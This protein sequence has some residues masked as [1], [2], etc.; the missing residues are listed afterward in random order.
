V[1]EIVRATAAH[2][3]E[4]AGTMRV[5]DVIGV[6]AGLDGGPREALAR[7]MRVSMDSW[8]C[9][10]DGRVL[11]MFGVAPGCVL[12]GAGSFW[13]AT[14]GLVETHRKTFMRACQVCLVDLRHRWPL[15]RA[16]IHG[17]HTRSIAWAKRMG[18]TVYPAHQHE[19]TSEMFHLVE[20]GGR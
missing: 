5:A 19:V 16:T 14:S 11:G 12:T 17:K 20:I 1:V 9:L 2:A 8:T 6:I 13:M 3:D 15:L 7:S 4:L 10:L 18:F